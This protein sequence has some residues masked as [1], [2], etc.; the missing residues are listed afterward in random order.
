MIAMLLCIGCTID[1]IARLIK[2]QSECQIRDWATD[3]LALE[4]EH[5]RQDH[6]HP[7]L[8]SCV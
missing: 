3:L 2:K 8:S 4:F 7:L 1:R 5:R 6:E